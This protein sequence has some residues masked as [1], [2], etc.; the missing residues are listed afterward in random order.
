MSEGLTVGCRCC[1]RSLKLEP[2]SGDFGGKYITY[3]GGDH[4]PNSWCQPDV[5]LMLTGD[6]REFVSV[7]PFD[8][9]R[10]VLCEWREKSRKLYIFLSVPC[11]ETEVCG[12]GEISSTAAVYSGRTDCLFAIQGVKM[13]DDQRNFC[14]DQYTHIPSRLMTR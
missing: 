11:C 5:W 9:W 14:R 12:S 13:G 2:E 8:W 7:H 3:R 1:N 4:R 6:R 10:V